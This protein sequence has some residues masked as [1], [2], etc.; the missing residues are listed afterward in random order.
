MAEKLH[1]PSPFGDGYF[2]RE[3]GVDEQL[4]RRLL[5]KALSRGGDFADLYFEHTVSDSVHLEDGRVDRSYGS[6]KLGVG[7]RTVQDDRVGY[8]FTEELTLEA[9]LS[10]AATAASLVD[11][12]AAALAS[13]FRPQRR[14]LYYPV[15]AQRIIIP[16][17]AKLPIVRRIH[18]TCL[19]LSPWVTKVSASFV[20]SVKR[21]LIVTS[22]GIVEE[23]CAPLGNLGAVVAVERRGR[24]ER[25]GW[26]L[27]GR[28][29]AVF[30]A[31]DTA[32]TIARKAV[33][34]ALTQLEA[35]QP[36]AGEFPVVLG[37]GFSGVLLH[38]AI[39]HGL[40]GDFNRKGTSTYCSSLGRKVA[41]PFVTIVDDGTL[42]GLAGSIHVDDEGT[43]SQRTVL[44]EGG[45]LNGFLH[46]RISARHYG[47]ASTGN[48]RRQD[49]MHHPIPRMRNT[50]MLP[51]QARPEDLI[52]EAGN[53]IY[54]EDVS[55]GQVRIGEGDFSFYVSQ[56]R[57]IENGKLGPPI[58][59]VNIM[60]NG[61]KLLANIVQVADDLQMFQGGGGLCGKDGQQVPVSFGL[62]TCL[63]RSLTVGG[64]QNVGERR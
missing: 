29:E 47:V 19:F 12:A 46:D 59:D 6:V 38:E 36:L 21:I 62:P 54:V 44:V 30:Y 64:V 50:F 11:Q 9:M 33:E 37:P 1:E 56:G 42:V 16:L 2:F 5:T 40:E 41:E 15:D 48:G 32:E 25:S 55:N 39:G 3:F 28:H 18:D 27:G 63:V 23:D 20:H 4:C 14:G 17:Q 57:L 60:G 35:V 52:K 22:D 51:G 13:G 10:A 8:G 45:V 49:F 53:G 24:R 26:N 61:P 7:I 43:P 34:R 58:K 31:L